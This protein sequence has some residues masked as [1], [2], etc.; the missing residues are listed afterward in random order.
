MHRNL[1]Q[2]TAGHETFSRQPCR[3]LLN[4]SFHPLGPTV[5]FDHIVFSREKMPDQDI[6]R[7]AYFERKPDPAHDLERPSPPPLPPPPPPPPLD[8][9]FQSPWPP[10]RPVQPRDHGF[11]FHYRDVDTS[12]SV[13]GGGFH[14]VDVSQ[15]QPP[16]P[17]PPLLPLVD[18]KQN[19]P[20]DNGGLPTAILV[21]VHAH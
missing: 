14:P 8:R 16:S 17:N 10:H 2:R 7:D 5:F 12:G 6:W 1:P 13:F 11:R 15:Q 19:Y 3:S 21:D 4:S 20:V 9:N 18:K